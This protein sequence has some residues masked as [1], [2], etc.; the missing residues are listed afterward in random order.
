MTMMVL[1]LTQTA[2]GS[3][4]FEDC[5][6][7][8]DRLDATVITLDVHEQSLENVIDELA[9]QLPCGLRLDLPALKAA[10][11]RIPSRVS[12]R[13][14][15]SSALGAMAGLAQT[16]G[17][18]DHR[19][20]VEVFGGEVVITSAQAA[21][22]MRFAE[23]YDVRDL[24]AREEAV[25]AALEP[26]PSDESTDDPAG[27]PPAGSPPRNPPSQTPDQPGKP[28]AAESAPP[29]DPVTQLAMMLSNHVDPD[30]W[31][32]F[33]G[34]RIEFDAHDSSLVLN[35]PAT[36]HRKL[37]ALFAKLRAARP[38]SLAFEVAILELPR[39][40]FTRLASRNELNSSALARALRASSEATL[41]WR[42]QG[43]VALGQTL[44][45]QSTPKEA[46]GGAT[47]TVEFLPTFEFDSNTLAIRIDAAWSDGTNH[48]MIRTTT[49]MPPAPEGGAATIE[50]PQDQSGPDGGTTRLLIITSRCV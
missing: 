2:L 7:L 44:A 4:E 30:D 27:E 37:A 29:R 35:A 10:G 19:P 50:F 21:A 48:C 20:R 15:A 5:L 26:Q 24:L 41:R 49:A 8:L 31:I 23:V 12:L 9:P 47:V 22:G 6:A 40:T 17:D 46:Q 42:A 28:S 1:A 38:A 43:V 25:N 34:D 11:L 39:A 18:E 45:V 3:A 36:T 32:R 13:I 33:G 14:M 16:L